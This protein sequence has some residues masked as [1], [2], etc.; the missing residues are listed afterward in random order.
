MASAM[1]KSLLLVAAVHLFLPA[2]SAACNPTQTTCPPDP[3]LGGSAFFDFTLGSSS[4]W[5][6]TGG[7]PTYNE[8][9]ASFTVA[10]SGDSP[11][12]NSNFYIMFGKV[13]VVMQTT[14]GG[15]LVSAVTL[16]SDDLDEIDWEWTGN[17]PDTVQSNYFSKGGGA[18]TDRGSTSPNPGHEQAFHKYSL[19]WTG[20]QMEWSIDDAVIRTVTAQH[21]GA[22]YP[23]TPMQV[24]VGAWSGGDSHNP[25]GTIQWAGGPTNYAAGPFTMIVKSITVADFSTGTSYS[26]GDTT[27]TLQSIKSL[28]GS[29][30][31]GASVASGPMSTASM[32]AS[33]PS[34]GSSASA[35]SLTG[36]GAAPTTSSSTGT[37]AGRAPSAVATGTPT[38]FMT[39]DALGSSVLTTVTPVVL[40]TT[41]AQ[42]PTAVTVTPIVLSSTSVG[43][44]LVPVTIT[45][46]LMPS[47]NEQGSPVLQALTPQITTSVDAQ[48]VPYPAVVTPPVSL[49]LSSQGFL[50]P[51]S[52]LTTMGL[53]GTMG[54]IGTVTQPPG[55]PATQT[56]TSTGK[57]AH[58][59][60]ID[61]GA[62]KP[63]STSMLG[64]VAYVVL[65]MLSFL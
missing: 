3:A 14:H 44:V 38:A 13:D 6:P 28:G 42:G 29:I 37:T 40:S 50:L 39:S 18:L 11:Q 61:N 20:T 34:A 60:P 52:N 27:G 1:S 56:P 49:A 46:A 41:D 24:K 4:M 2:L 55:S 21:S 36:I 7:A 25:P 47:T 31:P 15:G 32:G 62:C 45:P 16:Q 54:I 30:N 63:S 22:E 12:I 33:A 65:G 53:M 8:T 57:L 26:Y 58:S 10:K 23:Q 5:T 59:A 35:T 43:G 19:T 17:G 64:V 51:S 9:G 48:G